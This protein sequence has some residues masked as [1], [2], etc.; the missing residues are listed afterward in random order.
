MNG[1]EPRLMAR[2]AQATWTDISG[3]QPRA[4]IYSQRGESRGILPFRKGAETD[5]DHDIT[6]DV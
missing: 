2:A 6:L 3:E 4:H 1:D 5:S